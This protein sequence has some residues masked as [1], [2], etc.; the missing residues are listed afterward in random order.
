MISLKDKYG[1][2]ALVAGASEGLGAAYCYALAAQGI[3]IVMIARRKQLLEDQAR[4]IHDKHGVRVT[5]IA[6]D[7]ADPDIINV[8]KSQ[9]DGLHIDIMVYNAALSSIGPFLDTDIDTHLNIAAV[10]MNTTMCL[11]HHFGSEMVR[12]NK[13]AVILMAS[14]AGFQGSGFLTTYAS[15]KAFDRVLA[16]G[17]W[18]E[19]KDKG[20]DVIACCAGATST[21][22][23]INTKPA[24]L[25]IFAPKV[26]TP[27]EVVAECFKNIGSVPSF[28]TGRGNRLAAFFMNLMSRK[29]AVTIMGDTTRQMYN[30]N[31]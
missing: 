21:P 10:N 29:Q 6:C 15:T 4:A 24:K 3:D 23:Y 8:I 28:V 2:T 14:L 11:V 18:Y 7:L 9:I 22:N 27:E 20:V 1:H 17:L 31:Y 25:N 5:T 16:E 19:W 26:Q 13:G 30:I 12:R